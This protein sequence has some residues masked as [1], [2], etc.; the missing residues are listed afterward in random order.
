MKIIHRASEQP[1]PYDQLCGLSLIDKASV[2]DQ[3]PLGSTPKSN[4][5]TY[6]GVFDHIRELFAR[7]PDAKVR[8]YRPGRFSFNRPGGRC[9][10]CE[11]DG[12]K[13]IEMQFLPE[14]WVECV[15]CHGQR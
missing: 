15:D 12:Q 13:K 8:G 11:G 2:V 7:L 4:P 9:D 14:V 3:N 5:G 10:A 6:T 1:G